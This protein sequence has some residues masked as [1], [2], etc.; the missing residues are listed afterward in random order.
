MAST[1]TFSMTACGKNDTAKNESVHSNTTSSTSQ[2]SDTTPTPTL[3]DDEPVIFPTSMGAGSLINGS[4]CYL[5]D[6]KRHIFDILENK[7]Y[8]CNY[9]NFSYINGK[10]V[11]TTGST[12]EYINYKTGE[13]ILSS[14]DPIRSYIGTPYTFVCVEDKSF[15]GNNYSVGYLDVVNEEW[16]IEVSSEYSVCQYLSDYYIIGS[17]GDSLVL[18]LNPYSYC[19]NK[20]YIVYDILADSCTFVE[21]P[22]SM[23]VLFISGERFLVSE[24]SSDNSV[25]TYSIYDSTTNSFTKL[26]DFSSDSYVSSFGYEYTGKNGGCILSSGGNHIVFDDKLNVLDFDLSGYNIQALYVATPDILLFDATNSN[27]ELFTL[28][29]NK[30][31]DII[32]EGTD[33]GTFTEMIYVTD[34]LVAIDTLIFDYIINYAD[35]TVISDYNISTI[36]AYTNIVEVYPADSWDPNAAQMSL[37]DICASGH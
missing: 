24:Y 27:N 6:G 18:A 2:L 1:L 16:L 21:F 4:Y 10:Y 9:D 26:G 20:N 23:S 22:E 11:I 37:I 14:K 15:S 19:E 32:F 29:I 34:K 31:G 36:D 30:N 13:V 7:H 12:Y 28:A 25:I 33:V 5:Q 3:P 35:E 8:E 17:F